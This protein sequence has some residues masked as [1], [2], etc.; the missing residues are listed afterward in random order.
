MASRSFSNPARRHGQATRRCR[1]LI[2][3]ALMTAAGSLLLTRQSGWTFLGSR[4][5]A[6]QTTLLPVFTSAVA[7]VVF[8]ETS[9]AEEL[10]PPLEKAI[11]RFANKIQLG[12]DWLYFE[13]KP[14][15][16]GKNMEG[17]KKC[18]GSA[19]LGAYISPFES[20]IQFPVSQ[21]VEENPDSDE[22]G[23]VVADK[24]MT[25][26]FANIKERVDSEDWPGALEEW[27][28][29]TASLG[30]I[31]KGVNDLKEK[32]VFTLPIEGYERRQ[33]LFVQARREKLADRNAKANMMGFR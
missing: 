15:L 20:E 13:L 7:P 19:A 24:Q 2:A 8:P 25:T 5:S 14:A 18:L 6:V 30:K 3:G 28:A 12:M 17:T 26:A 23:W 22:Q 10:V 11:D 21:L 16:V 1:L 33:E 29:T 31:M 32:E 4:R 9:R 27:K